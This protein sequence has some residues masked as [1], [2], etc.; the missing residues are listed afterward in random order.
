MEIE[1][2]RVSKA[3][4]DAFVESYPRPLGKPVSVGTNILQWRDGDRIVAAYTPQD[5]WIVRVDA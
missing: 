2:K 5:G 1:F 3:E 4:L